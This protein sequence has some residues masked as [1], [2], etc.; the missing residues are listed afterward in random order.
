MR[1]CRVPLAGLAIGLILAGVFL[2]HQTSPIY[3]CEGSPATAL[4]I[5]ASVGNVKGGKDAAPPA[6][7]PVVAQAA[8][9]KRDYVMAV[10]MGIKVEWLSIYVQSWKR[11]S[12]ATRLVVFVDAATLEVRAP[13][14]W[15][16]W[17]SRG[18]ALQRTTLPAPVRAGPTAPTPTCPPSSLPAQD[19]LTVALFKDFDVEVIEFE[20]PPDF[21][22][23]VYR[24]HLYLGFVN[25]NLHTIRGIAVSDIKDVAVQVRAQ[26]AGRGVQV[27]PL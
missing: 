22:I 6:A 2:T 11:W 15:G 3:N 13:A 26:G 18:G 16:Q 21:A 17:Q 10:S 24:F 19:P 9:P 25:L 8:G 4:R 5:T 12:P 7:V 27:P 20:L 1:E 14:R 23:H